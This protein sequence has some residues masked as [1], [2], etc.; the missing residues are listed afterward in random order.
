MAQRTIIELVD[1]IDG[2]AAEETVAFALDGAAYEIDLNAEH[3]TDLREVMAGYVAAARRAGGSARASRSTAS[4]PKP[5][6]ADS[7]DPKAVRAWAH[8]H[9]ITVNTRGRLKAEVL[10]QYRAAGN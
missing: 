4:A 6:S 8:S 3:A 10:E 1:D 7:V 2:T 9:G 5:R